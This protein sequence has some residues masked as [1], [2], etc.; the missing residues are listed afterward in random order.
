[1][2]EQPK[3]N[4]EKKAEYDRLFYLKKKEEISERRKIRIICSCGLEICKRHLGSHLVRSIHA[5]RL[6][7]IENF[8]LLPTDG[9]IVLD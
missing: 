4:K 7:I 8:V 9:S 3:T 6:H 2:E 5:T 1:M